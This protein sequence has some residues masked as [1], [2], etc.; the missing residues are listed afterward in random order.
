MQGHRLGQ[1]GAPDQ[2]GGNPP[3]HMGD[4]H[5]LRASPALLS[6]TLRFLSPVPVFTLLGQSDS[7]QGLVLCVTVTYMNRGRSWLFLLQMFFGVGEH[8]CSGDEQSLTSNS[9][10]VLTSSPLRGAPK[11]CRGQGR[12]HTR[13]YSFH[14]RKS[15][16]GLGQWHLFQHRGQCVT[17][18]GAATLVLGQA[19]VCRVCAAGSL[20]CFPP[21]PTTLEPVC[22]PPAPTPG[23]GPLRGNMRLPINHSRMSVLPAS[24][25]TLI[26]CLL[27]FKSC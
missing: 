2:W 7:F 3:A 21:P 13:V 9:L 15:G 26:S 22:L 17:E 23:D 25:I 19:W 8:L 18:A 1:T 4:G 27:V 12:V 24:S 16:F 20:G 14:P 11:T 6:V 5:S 10:R